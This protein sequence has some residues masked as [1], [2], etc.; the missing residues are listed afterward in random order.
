MKDR[1]TLWKGSDLY[2]LE[3]WLSKH[4]G[5]ACQYLSQLSLGEVSGKA[6][7]ALT[8]FV[9]IQLLRTDRRKN[10]YETE[11]LSVANSVFMPG[12]A[13]VYITNDLENMKTKVRAFFEQK[14]DISIRKML[15]DSEK[16]RRDINSYRVHLVRTNFEEPLPV[17]DNPVWVWLDISRRHSN[18]VANIIFPIGRFHLLVWSREQ[19][20]YLHSRGYSLLPDTSEEVWKNSILNFDEWVAWSLEDKARMEAAVGQLIQGGKWMRPLY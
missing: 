3:K 7:E 12:S 2:G 1:Y 6:K 16:M 14:K 20:D 4:E 19:I 17:S 5:E 11:L 8:D 9:C 15:T 13:I 10:F 18:P